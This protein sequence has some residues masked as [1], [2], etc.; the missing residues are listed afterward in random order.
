M[1]YQLHNEITAGRVLYF[2]VQ[3]LSAQ[4]TSDHW[5]ASS[6]PLRGSFVIN[7]AS[8]SP[9]SAWQCAQKRPRTPSFHFCTTNIYVFKLTGLVSVIMQYYHNTWAIMCV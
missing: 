9:V 8:S 7:F 5:V 4:Q 6:N 1:S 2:S 3:K